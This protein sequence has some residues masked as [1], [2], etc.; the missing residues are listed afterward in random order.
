[1][2]GFRAIL[3]PLLLTWTIW[4]L[5][6]VFRA[7]RDGKNSRKALWLALLTGFIFALGIYTYI[8]YRITP[9]LLLL[10]VPFFYKYPHFWKR[11]GLFAAVAFVTALPLLYYFAAN[12][13]SFF[14]R[15]SEISV[16]SASSPIA[17]FAANFGKTL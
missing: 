5:L 3:A 16:T 6:K 4:L 17:T 1:R 15:T 12:P 8:A 2:I 9:V 13:G 14:G 11:V 7:P 10:F